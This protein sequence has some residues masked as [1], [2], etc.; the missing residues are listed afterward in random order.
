MHDYVISITYLKN[1]NS[2]LNHPHSDTF[3]LTVL[4]KSL[5]INKYT[6]IH[7][8]FSVKSSDNQKYDMAKKQL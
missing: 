4:K 8:K 3:T 1:Y 6:N 2:N 5:H 7:K